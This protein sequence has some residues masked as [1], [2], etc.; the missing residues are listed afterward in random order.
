MRVTHFEKA[1][2]D[3]NVLPMF[4]QKG[5][6]AIESSQVSVMALARVRVCLCPA[7]TIAPRS[8]QPAKPSLQRPRK[9]ILGPGPINRLIC[10][11]D[12]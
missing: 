6:I 3:W 12:F 2:G 8:Y 5:S 4:G 9:G 7:E 1:E 10:R 11:I